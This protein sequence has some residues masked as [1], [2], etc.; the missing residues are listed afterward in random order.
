VGRVTVG[1]VILRAGGESVQATAE[2][3]EIERLEKELEIVGGGRGK[4]CAS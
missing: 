4:I 2:I 3:F 1:K